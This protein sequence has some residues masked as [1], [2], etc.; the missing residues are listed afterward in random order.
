M[1]L[2]NANSVLFL[3]VRSTT[4]SKAARNVHAIAALLLAIIETLSALVYICGTK[5][6]RQ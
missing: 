1:L 3:P 5:A 4:A 6:N 2:T